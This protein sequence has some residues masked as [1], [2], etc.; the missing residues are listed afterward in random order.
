MSNLSSQVNDFEITCVGI[1]VYDIALPSLKSMPYPGELVQIKTPIHQIGGS[2]ANTAIGLSKLGRKVSVIGYVGNDEIA[3][4]LAKNLKDNN[5]ETSGVQF[6][7]V[8]NTSQSIHINL[9]GDDRRFIHYVGANADLTVSCIKENL[10]KNE[11]IKFP[12]IFILSGYLL[13]PGLDA[14]D[15]KDLFKSL[16]SKNNLIFLDVAFNVSDE[17]LSEKLKIIL[18]FVDYF[19]PNTFESLVLTGK[20]KIKEQAQCYLDWGAKSVVITDGENGSFYMNQTQSISV[21]ALSVESID[22]SGAGDAFMAGLVYGITESWPVQKSLR[23]ASVLGAS[24]SMGL[25]CTTTLYSKDEALSRIN[26]IELID[27]N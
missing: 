3:I 26:E 7:P 12:H 2:A 19:L 4:I 22:G 9:I 8:N 21:G 15:L 17:N 5:I 20:H 14:N 16:K 25:G 1:L 18:P 23:F 11:A 10:R 13:L 24:V 6:S 27:F